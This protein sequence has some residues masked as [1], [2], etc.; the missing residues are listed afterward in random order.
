MPAPRLQCEG[1]LVPWGQRGARCGAE[2]GVNAQILLTEWVHA[3]WGPRPALSWVLGAELRSGTLGARARGEVMGPGR[4]T[5]SRLLPCISSGCAG[6]HPRAAQAPGLVLNSPRVG[7]TGTLLAVV[8]IRACLQHI[9]CH[10]AHEACCTWLSPAGSGPLSQ[11]LGVGK[12][13]TP[14]PRRARQEVGH[15][16][17]AELGPAAP[18]LGAGGPRKGRPWA[19]RAELRLPVARAACRPPPRGVISTVTGVVDQVCSRPPPWAPRP[20]AP[21]LVLC[22]DGWAVVRRRS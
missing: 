6:G 14:S 15:S 2:N 21:T 16:P 11:L 7:F 13:R 20:S 10:L 5:L 17:A 12:N 1:L 4:K 8:P 18:V 22:Q 3:L 19:W 9:A